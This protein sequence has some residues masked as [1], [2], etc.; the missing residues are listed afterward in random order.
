MAKNMES[1]DTES[2]PLPTLVTDRF[3]VVKLATK[4]LRQLGVK[5]RWKELD[6]K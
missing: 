5:Y 2:F 3:H 4:E 6:K 1:S